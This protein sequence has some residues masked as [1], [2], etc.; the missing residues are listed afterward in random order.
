[1]PVRFQVDG[2]FYDH[3]K[4]IGL[5]D[6]AV[7]LWTRAG[8]YS[9]HKL[10]N[11]FVPDAS[12]HLV[13]KV[14]DAADELV[15]A[16]LWRRGKKDGRTGYFFH[17]WDQR[18]LTKERVEAEQAA[19]RERK[20]IARAVRADRA[21]SNASPQAAPQNVRPDVRPESDRTP[22]GTPGGIPSM[23]V[24]VSVSPSVVELGETDQL[25][26][27]GESDDPDDEYEP[28]R[29]QD[30]PR[31]PKVD[32]TVMRIVR[33]Y[34]AK[35]RLC[36]PSKIAM[37]I[38]AATSDW[39]LDVIAKAVD[40][41]ANESRSVTP[42][43]LRIELRKLELPDKKGIVHYDKGIWKDWETGVIR[44]RRGNPIGADHPRSNSMV[45]REG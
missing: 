31:G 13:T 4:S 18:N 44:T 29:V 38:N 17:Q 5:S 45:W 14:P 22:D 40:S 20:R 8:S 12:L 23:S 21:S 42:D 33:A 19:D 25:G 28:P 16:K 37:V 11:G 32:L 7:A 6:A 24:S 43:A 1:M 2:D 3:P 30:E 39:D 34:R 36:D 35:V 15:Q 27:A 10:L 9:A 41:L 26:N